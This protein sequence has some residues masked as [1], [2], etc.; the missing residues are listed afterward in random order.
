MP[1]TYVYVLFSSYLSI[2]LSIYLSRNY[3]Y[4]NSTV[5]PNSFALNAGKQEVRSAEIGTL[6]PVF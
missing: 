4:S 3:K 6:A 5:R 2:Y 1:H